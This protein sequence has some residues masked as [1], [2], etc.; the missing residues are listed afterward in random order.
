MRVKEWLFFLA[1][2]NGATYS[3]S[4]NDVV[5]TP[6]Q[7][8]LPNSPDGWISQ[9]V[10]LAKNMTYLGLDRSFTVP[11]RFVRQGAKIL[12]SLVYNGSI[13][14]KVFLVVLKL[15]SK[16]QIHETYY[17]GEI[18]FSQMDDQDSYFDV[19]L[20]E[21]G[22]MYFIKKNEDVKYEIPL[23]DNSEVIRLSGINL[24]QSTT[25][26]LVGKADQFNA[27]LFGGHLPASSIISNEGDNVPTSVEATDFVPL[28]DNDPSDNTA[29]YNTGNLIF[30]ATTTST[31]TFSPDF[32]FKTGN[33]RTG[34]TGIQPNFPVAGIQIKVDLR[35]FNSTGTFKQSLSIY[36]SDNV[37]LYFTEAGLTSKNLVRHH[38]VGNYQV[39]VENGDKVFLFIYATH[40]RPGAPL[41]GGEWVSFWYNDFEDPTLTPGT[42]AFRFDFLYPT[43]PCRA[44]L[45]GDLFTRMVSKISNGQFTGNADFIRPTGDGSPTNPFRAILV[46]SGDGVRQIS[47]AVIK[48]SFKDC[49]K[50][51]DAVKSVGVR[52]V[53]NV[54]T[55]DSRQNCLSGNIAY[56]LGVVKKVRILPADKFY[57]SSVKVGFPS[58]DYED[59]NGRYE[60]NNTSI[61]NAPMGRIVNE[62]DLTSSFRGDSYGIEFLRVNTAGKTT[63]DNAS[64]NS[65]FLIDCIGYLDEGGAVVWEPF[66][67]V[68]YE[69]EGLLSST[70]YNIGISP[71]RL[72]SIHGGYLRSVLY[73]REGTSL[74]YQ[75]TDKNSKLKTTS[76]T[77]AVVDE[78]ADM[79]IGLLGQPFFKPF[80]IEFTTK[81]PLGILDVVQMSRSGMIQITD[82]K[83]RTYSGALIDGGVKPTTKE[84]QSWSIL[85]SINTDLTK[86]I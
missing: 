38:I 25:S 29:V 36:T 39:S 12:R 56:D 32:E 6:T 75:T 68:F 30:Q 7:T 67:Q 47:D 24:K 35:I 44:L 66:R 23:D 37:G 43:T 80:I 74:T 45:L 79:P 31:V 86:R 19:N 15:N 22:V 53:Q 41:V 2:E 5:T 70:V 40:W 50:S 14:A 49:Y 26:L 85:C 61:F 16:T 69:V 17:K 77:G 8:P 20:A 46:T 1:D 51:I 4:G 60:F 13:E 42:T 83:G 11:L 64:D 78:D 3:V 28:R 62:L 73:K 71:K 54:L 59:N 21:G 10:S 9:G 65:V 81:Y 18:D 55:I 48:T 34:P 27:T 84:E 76:I 33:Y 63:T 52:N 58:S 57:Y 82:Y 72:L